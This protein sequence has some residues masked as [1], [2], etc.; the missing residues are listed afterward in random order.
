VAFAIEKPILGNRA[1][2]EVIKTYGQD[3]MSNGFYLAITGWKKRCSS[4][5]F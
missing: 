3:T 1:E 4:T 2:L 5:I